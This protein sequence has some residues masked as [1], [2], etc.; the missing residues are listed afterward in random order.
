MPPAPVPEKPA[1]SLTLPDSPASAEPVE[2]ETDPEFST[3]A[4][5]VANSNALV[6]TPSPVLTTTFPTAPSTVW[7]ESA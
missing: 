2:I 1:T 6:A 7:D 4:S 3:L 5:P